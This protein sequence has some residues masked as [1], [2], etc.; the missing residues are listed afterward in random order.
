[1]SWLRAGSAN[2][3]KQIPARQIICR[4]G[5]RPRILFAEDSY[6]ARTLTAALLTKMGCE[7]DAVEHGE[8]A[9]NH[10]SEHTYDLILL[11]IEMPVMDGVCAA[12]KI[13]ELG[14]APA[15]VPIMALSAFLADTAKVASIREEFDSALAKPAG[16]EALHDAIQ[17]MLDGNPPR[18]L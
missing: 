13:R 1:M 12:R 9:L 8:H 2:A 6:A 17:T 15:H 10:A 7:V 14:G 11:D 16:R 3:P 4:D 18:A 5:S